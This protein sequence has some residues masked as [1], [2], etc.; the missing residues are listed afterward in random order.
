MNA[1]IYARYSSSNQ[2]EESIEGQVRECKA[3]AEKNG[4]TIVG[5]YIDRAR[6]ARTDNRPDF[7]KM[8]KDSSK[9][10]FDTIIVW[11]FDRFARN[12]YDS[13]HYKHLLRKNSVQVISA[14]EN[15]A[16]GSN[17]IIMETFLEGMAEYYSADLSEKVI[18]GITENALKCKFNGGVVPLGY[19]V[20]KEHHLQID[21]LTAP[22]VLDAFQ[23]YADGKS[24]KEVAEDMCCKGI[25]NNRGGKITFNVLTHMFHNRRY[26]GEYK[27]RD[28]IHPNGIP[29]IVPLDLF[30]KVQ[31][32]MAQT[33]KAPA[34]H[35][36]E[37]DYL[38]SP[39]LYCG[40]CNRLMVGESGTSKTSKKH[41]Y[42]KCS[43]VKKFHDCN[44]KTIGKDALEAIVLKQIENVYMDDNLI[45]K[46]ANEVLKEQ[47]KENT[48]L[49]LLKKKYAETVKG[50]SNMLDAIQN[51][52]LT[53]STK[54]RLESLELQK[55]DLSLKITKEELERPLLTKEQIIEWLKDLRKYGTKRLDHKRRLINTF[56]NSV[57]LYD[58]KIVINFNYKDGAK[59]VRVDEVKNLL[60]SS[61]SNVYALPKTKKTRNKRVFF[62]FGNEACLR[63]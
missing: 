16:E 49:P 48:T 46:I 23:N 62:V 5:I 2:R 44:K 53:E 20:D 57:Y 11:K 18:R 14:T 34:K 31:D 54:E 8:I 35:K 17:G 58:D 37:D 63:P 3:Y 60:L 41:H 25:R 61:D 6:S 30:E 15:I 59:T 45:E 39:K 22:A 38:L 32:R 21:P 13:A 7:Q 51:G 36:A 43:G 24:M 33:K 40:K 10:K 19:V 26:I 56:V 42:Y 29:A 4:Q 28:I 47:A 12:R 1:V 9:K 27:Y 55:A 50:I 52:I